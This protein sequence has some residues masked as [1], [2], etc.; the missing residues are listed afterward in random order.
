M[1]QEQPTQVGLPQ[2]WIRKKRDGESLSQIEIAAFIQGV[3][4]GQ[5]TEAQIAAMSMAIYFQDLSVD[6]RVSLTLAVRDSGKV[7]SWDHGLSLIHI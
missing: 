2:E 5:V 3:T 6:E 7:L 4:S 1:K